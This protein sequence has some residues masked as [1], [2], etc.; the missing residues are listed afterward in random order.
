MKN[1]SIATDEMT[2][3]VRGVSAIDLSPLGAIRLIIVEVIMELHWQGFARNAEWASE[4]WVTPVDDSH[5]VVFC[6][7]EPQ[8]SCSI[9]ATK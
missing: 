8:Q 1:E 5:L 7:L 6:T 9:Q 4:P 2:T 3:H